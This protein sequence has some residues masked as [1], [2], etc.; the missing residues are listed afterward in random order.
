MKEDKK[1]KYKNNNKEQ[2][3][4]ISSTNTNE[5]ITEYNP[6]FC[7]QPRIINIYNRKYCM[8]WLTIN[9]HEN[10]Y[11]YDYCVKLFEIL[12]K[13][14]RYNG[15]PV[16]TKEH[17]LLGKFISLMYLLSNKRDYSYNYLS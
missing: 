10:Y 2:I 17:V 12:M 9:L 7:I 6:N 15:F 16:K 11:H 5:N 8:K 4:N 13:W 14:T 1:N 3:Y